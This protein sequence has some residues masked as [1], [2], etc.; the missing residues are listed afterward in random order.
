MVETDIIY[1]V[2]SLNLLSVTS[3][4]V[5]E[6]WSDDD[7]SKIARIVEKETSCRIT[8]YQYS[9]QQS[10]CAIFAAPYDIAG[11]GAVF[12]L[13]SIFNE[14]RVPNSLVLSLESIIVARS[15]RF[16]K[17]QSSRSITN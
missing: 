5:G 14:R 8:S 9:V 11:I 1:G 12:I 6:L 15:R 7:D 2:P 10:T 13:P 17:I 4:H 16:P 3:I